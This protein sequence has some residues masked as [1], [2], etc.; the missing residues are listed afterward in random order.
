MTTETN[1][2]D[3][4]MH[5][6]LCKHARGEPEDYAAVAHRRG[7]HGIVFTCHN[8][9]D[10]GWSP[11]VRMDM[12]DFD[13]YVRMIER[14]REAWKG[15]I[16]IRLGLECDYVPGMEAGLEKILD[17]AEFHH[18][19][20]S[21][22]PH[23]KD[24]QNRYFNGDPVAFQH[25]Y[26]E[27]LAL[28]AESGLF[29]TLSHPDLVKNIAPEVWSFSQM[30]ETIGAALDRIASAGTAM[31]L[32]TSGLLKALPEM[33]PGP[34]MLTQ[35]RKRGI[36]VV[37][38]SD[39]HDPERV[40]DAF[41]DAFDILTAVGYT[42]INGVLGRKLRPLSIDSARKALRPLDS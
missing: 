9:T 41:E 7:L 25:T 29:D 5:T 17:R 35:M 30:E 6:P 22:H 21:V 32:N 37:V 20:G 26:F 19:L 10:D 14:A 18:V 27:H 31:E 28:A 38:G 36:P 34:A 2:Y 12:A 16:D 24:Y 1:L 23:L 3:L 42:E 15:R 11:G 33:N 13:T 39:A 8:P 40:A 4:H